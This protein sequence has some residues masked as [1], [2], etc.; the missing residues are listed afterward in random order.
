MIGLPWL[1]SFG[2]RT[3]VFEQLESE[4]DIL[5]A[6][7]AHLFERKDMDIPQG[8]EKYMAVAYGIE[9]TDKL[10]LASSPPIEIPLPPPEK[11]QE[12]FTSCPLRLEVAGENF[13]S[14][15]SEGT[16]IIA[17]S[18]VNW[19]IPSEVRTIM[20]PS[21]IRNLLI[22]IGFGRKVKVIDVK[23]NNKQ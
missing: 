6:L 13:Q 4:E 11:R 7:E 2:T 22:R 12:M 5:R 19:S 1:E 15:Y 14:T 10:F 21:K 3:R 9:K 16:V 17:N 8:R 18:W 20:T 23:T